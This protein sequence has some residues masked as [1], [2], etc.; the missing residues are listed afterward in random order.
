[1]PLRDV[2]ELQ[3]EGFHRGIDFALQ[4]E[5]R[6]QIDGG[7][8]EPERIAQ[9]VGPGF[10][11]ALQHHDDIDIRRG[12]QSAFGRRT[13]QHDG[14]EFAAKRGLTGFDKVVQR[15]LHGRFQRGARCCGRSTA[16]VVLH[17]N[18]LV[19]VLIVADHAPA[20]F[21]FCDGFAAFESQALVRGLGRLWP[22]TRADIGV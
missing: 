13:K 16:F 3:R 12:S 22:K 6:A 5:H 4:H 1:M 19:V 2:G 20:V 21:Q 17:L 8:S 18:L 15:R 10:F 14:D 11:K 7:F 9:P